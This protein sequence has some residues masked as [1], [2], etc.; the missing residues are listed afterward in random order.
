MDPSPD[1]DFTDEIEWF[2][3]SD[4]GACAASPTATDTR[5]SRTRRS[6]PY[7]QR[8]YSALSSSATAVTDFFASP[9]SIVVPSS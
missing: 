2:M 1:Y 9:N 7:A 8:L 6:K 3:T 5:R 4:R